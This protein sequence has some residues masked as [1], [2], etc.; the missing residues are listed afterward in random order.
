MA[1]TVLGR[2]PG[3]FRS[4][5]DSGGAY[6]VYLSWAL[7]QP[8]QSPSPA[9]GHCPGIQLL[10]PLLSSSAWQEELLPA[11]WEF[12][13]TQHKSNVHIIFCFENYDTEK[14]TSIFATRNMYSDGQKRR[15]RSEKA[16][17]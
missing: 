14:L 17:K 3:E 11:S 2:F 16:E 15:R 1:G 8:S 4:T 10:L 12:G 13:S 9:L 5:L 7:P 6:R